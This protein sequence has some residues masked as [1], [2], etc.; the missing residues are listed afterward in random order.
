MPK[1]G[2]IGNFGAIMQHLTFPL[3]CLISFSEIMTDDRYEQVGKSNCF[4]YFLG[5]FILGSKW[6]RV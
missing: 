4:F 3:I 2:R 1:M 5:K 6:G